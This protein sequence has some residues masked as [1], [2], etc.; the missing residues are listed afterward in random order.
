M[1]VD[2]ARRDDRAAEVL[3]RRPGASPAPTSATSP[4]SIRSQPRSCSVPASSIVTTHALREDHATSSGTSSKRSTSTRP[5]SVIFSVGITDSARNA[6]CWNGDSSLQPSVARRG[7]APRATRAT[8]LVERRVRE[9]ARRPAAAA[10]RAPRRRRRR[11]SRRRCSRAAARRR[12]ST[13]R[14]C[15]RRRRCARRARP[16]TRARRAAARSRARSRARSGRC[17]GGARSTAIFARSRSGSASASPRAVRAAPRRATSVTIW[18]GTMPITR[19]A[20]ARATG[21]G[22]SPGRA[23]RCAPCAAP[24]PGTSARGI[25]AT[26][27][28]A[29][30][31][32]LGHEALE[33]GQDAAGRPGSRARSRRGGRARARAAGLSVAQT[34]AS[35]GGMPNATA[36]RTIE[37]MWPSSAMCSGSRSSVQNAIRRGPYSASERQQRVRGC[38]RPTPRGSAATCRRAAARGPP[39]RVYASWSERMPA[40][41]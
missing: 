29:L 36:S 12:P 33:V 22:T 11:R 1:R 15:R 25:S 8:H 7:D 2:E 4:S 40:A 3:A 27:A 18:P 32:E 26:G 30:Q 34:S 38:A 19:A 37:L 35:S 17:R 16:S 14:S 23:R 24:S 9:Q 41:A 10:R 28:P 20:A 13:R 31:H 21:C 5:R 6:R 39:R